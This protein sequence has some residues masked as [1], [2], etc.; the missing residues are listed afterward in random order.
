MCKGDMLF[1]SKLFTVFETVVLKVDICFN[2]RLM[3]WADIGGKDHKIYR[4]KMDGTDRKIIVNNTK[5]PTS[6]VLSMY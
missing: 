6:K 2:F 3:F 4:A 5:N 1:F